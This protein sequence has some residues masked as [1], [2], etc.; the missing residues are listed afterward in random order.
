MSRK[1][2]YCGSSGN[3]TKEHI[4]PKCIIEYYKGN[5][6]NY[7]SDI[8]RE[9]GGDATVKNVCSKCNN[10]VL[11]KLDKYLC[12][13]YNEKISEVVEHGNPT[14]LE[15]N[16]NMLSRALL[17][18]SYNSS[19]TISGNNPEGRTSAKD[20]E[21]IK[22]SK[23]TLRKIRDYILGERGCLPNL[24]IKLMIVT[25][26]E[27]EYEAGGREIMEPLIFRTGEMKYEGNLS[28]R[29]AK[30]IV[31]IKS[32]W[33]YIFY[34]K[35]RISKK[36]YKDFLRG[37]DEWEIPTGK[38]LPKNDGSINFEVEDT[39]FFIPQMMGDILNSKLENLN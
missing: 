39:T 35:R 28:H 32:Y 11:S 31:A 26:S 30:R 15:Y 7:R 19:R 38:I 8:D 33:F 20:K 22:E 2:A 9:F 34:P 13:I 10:E 14:T 23:R 6:T 36:K 18:I 16:Y 37:V 3:L 27:I 21:M 29:F 1:C 4:W 5:L 12:S 17:K 25:D 24:V